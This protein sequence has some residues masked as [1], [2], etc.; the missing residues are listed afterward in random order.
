MKQE[1][2]DKLTKERSVKIFLASL[3]SPKT[4]EDYLRN[5]DRFRQYAEFDG[6]DDF[7]LRDSKDI[8][9]LVEDYVLQMRENEHPNTIPTHYYPIQSFLEMND[10]SINFKKIRRLFPEKKK[11]AVERGWTTDE[12]QKMLSIT[13]DLRTM[14]I[15]YFENASG[16]RIG[17]FDELQ[18]KHLHE[19]NDETY[20]KCY[21]ITG[22]AESKEEYMTFLTP[23]AT[24]ALDDYLNYRKS[25]GHLLTPDDFV[26]TGKKTSG[27]LSTSSK[28]LG[29]SV[30]YVAKKAGLR[31]PLT[32]KGSRYPIPTNHG[33]RHR[34]NE[35]LK[36]SNIVNPHIVEKFLSHKSRLIPLDS[37][38]FS[39]NIETMFAEYKKVIPLLTIDPSE[40][41][42][43]EKQDL[44]SENSKLKESKEN[45]EQQA[46]E[47]EKLTKMVERLQKY[48]IE[49][50]VTD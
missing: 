18:I 40:R 27:N 33:F 47:I 29:A 9:R 46:L 19:I 13:T 5:L 37:V 41:L 1:K 8:Q 24:K 44:E 4:K 17:L 22:Y 14:A 3:K 43:L 39:P 15:I 35:L 10:V 38:Y 26:F 49:P 2:T 16:G 31:N 6:F 25:R 23:E 11:T 50:S 12:V 45:S 42:L 32:K 20:G 36:S 48:V 34:F 28:N 21:A 7:V 30:V